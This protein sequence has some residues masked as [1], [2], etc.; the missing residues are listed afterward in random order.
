[1][2]CLSFLS[3]AELTIWMNLNDY[4]FYLVLS[5]KTLGKL[6]FSK[7]MIREVSEVK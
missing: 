3:E 5:L 7:F 4:M 1:M 6:K 2:G